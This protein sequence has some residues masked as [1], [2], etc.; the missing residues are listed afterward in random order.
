[1][2]DC[3][4]SCRS[5]VPPSDRANERRNAARRR[6]PVALLTGS[7]MFAIGAVLFVGDF[8]GA[9]GA[10]GPGA[11]LDLGPAFE[12]PAAPPEGIQDRPVRA[13]RKAANFGGGRA[14][15]VRLCDGFFFPSVML[16]GGDEACASQCPD[17]PTAFYSEPAGSD[18][19]EDAVS[20]RGESYAALPAAD[21]HRTAF[22]GACTCHRSLTRSYLADLLRDRT[23]RDGDLV[24]TAKGFTVYR[25][26]R[27]SALSAAN[28][29]ALSQSSGVPKA[30]LPEL[31]A[32]ER[33]GAWD[34][35][36]GS[37]SHASTAAVAAA[38]AASI[39]RLHRGTVTVDDAAP[40]Q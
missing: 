24:M 29:V 13:K 33:A 26:D 16:S 30:S 12:A 36:S 3:Q 9:R 2:N 34:R 10:F 32:M 5:P 35:Q 23:L 20:L 14:I 1:V 37:Y 21:R 18:R 31:A 4:T 17:A 25:S 38:E 22:D 8:A 11:P 28:F 6:L 15:C 40:P 27:S 19:I 7:A 39:P